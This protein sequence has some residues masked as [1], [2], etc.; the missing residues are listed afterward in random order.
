MKER[1]GMAMIEEAPR[2]R[3]RPRDTDKDEAIRQA[4]WE[5]LA[6]RGYDNLTFE[7][8]AEAANCSRTTLYRRFAGKCEMVTSAMY[9]TARA[10]ER[11]MP[12][13]AEPR[14]MLIAHSRNMATYLAD[15]RGRA[16][17]SLTEASWREPDLAA[18]I[19]QSTQHDRELYFGML[20]SLCPG[21]TEESVMLAYDILV[22]TIL[23]H[24]VMLQ[25]PFAAE[26]V[27][28]VV[29]AATSVLRSA[30]PAA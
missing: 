5:V 29:D 24:V 17:V 13:V 25:S 2:G 6:A 12:V 21:A 23:F 22:G 3:G 28:T 16:L 19:Q 27:E 18:A 1:D 9:E 26:K 30:D 8:V 7:A 15:E 11:G 14:A 10:L 4:T 20:R